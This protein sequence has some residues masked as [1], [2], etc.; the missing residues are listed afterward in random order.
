MTAGTDDVAVAAPPR[1]RPLW[2]GL[3]GW[4]LVALLAVALALPLVAALRVVTS[5]RDDD[6]TP[7]DVVVVLGAAQFN[8][9]PSPVLEARLAHADEL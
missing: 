4:C 2:R 5:A 6:R 7:A 9:R 8:G 3:L 1:R